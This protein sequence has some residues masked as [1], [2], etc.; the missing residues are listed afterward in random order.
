MNLTKPLLIPIFLSYGMPLFAA[1]SGMASTGLRAILSLLLI[2]AL[3]FALAWALKRYGPMARVKKSFGLDIL[4]QVGLGAKTNLTLIR[5][6]RSILLIGVTSNTINLLKDME[7]GDFERSL[8]QVS[9]Q[10]GVHQ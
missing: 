10:P 3:M 8:S 9:Q 1:D 7:E 5:V 2:I 4:G 6:G